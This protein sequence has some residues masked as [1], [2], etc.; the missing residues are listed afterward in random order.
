MA[1]NASSHSRIHSKFIFPFRAL[2]K[3]TQW[4]DEID[5]N[6][7]S[8][9]I[10]LFNHWTSLIDLGDGMSISGRIYCGFASIQLWVTKYPRNYPKLTLNVHFVGFNFIRCWIQKPASGVSCD[11]LPKVILPKRHQCKPPW[12]NQSNLQTSYWPIVSMW[13]QRSSA[14]TTLLCSRIFHA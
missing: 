3:L 8:A 11:Y 9:T 5:M 7:F 10:R 2:K 12:W 6:R 4:L 14:Q 1:W 13:L